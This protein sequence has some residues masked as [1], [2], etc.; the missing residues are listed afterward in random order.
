MNEALQLLME[1]ELPGGGWGG[2]WACN[3]QDCHTTDPI[4]TPESLV[5]LSLGKKITLVKA[6]E[7]LWFC[8]Q[9]VS[10]CVLQDYIVW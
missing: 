8:L 2:W 6:R 9:V 1:S 10:S 7:R 5:W 4:S 3:A